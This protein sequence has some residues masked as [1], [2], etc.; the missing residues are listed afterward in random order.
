MHF[1]ECLRIALHCMRAG[2]L[3]TVLTMLGIVISVSLVIAVSAINSWFSDGFRTSMSSLVSVM[4]V[5]MATSVTPGG[6]G[7]RRLNDT[8]VEALRRE[9]DSSTIDAIA[10]VVQGFAVIRSKPEEYRGTVIGSSPNYLTMTQA[11][12]RLAQRSPRSSTGVKLVLLCWQPMLLRDCSVAT[13]IR[14][15][16]STSKLGGGRFE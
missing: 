13:D 3:R 9:V 8:D 5:S 10:P 1:M 12:S 15:S 7:S 11:C 6:N 4:S 14:R 2:R 16:A